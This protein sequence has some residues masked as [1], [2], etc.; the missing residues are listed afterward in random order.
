MAREIKAKYLLLNT[1]KNIIKVCE[2]DPH[3]PLGDICLKSATV[4]FLDN[5]SVEILGDKIQ[6]DFTHYTIFTEDMNINEQPADNEIEMKHKSIFD[7]SK[8]K[9]SPA[10]VPAG[11]A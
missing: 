10:L 9:K 5:N 7:F 4:K 2:T 3:I 6:E 1:S 11:I 8:G